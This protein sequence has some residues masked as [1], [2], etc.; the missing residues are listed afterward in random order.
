MEFCKAKTHAVKPLL[1]FPS[2]ARSEKKAPEIETDHSLTTCIPR[3]PHAQYA[4]H[5]AWESFVCTAY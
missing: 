3:F 2:G 4:V 5:I 1:S